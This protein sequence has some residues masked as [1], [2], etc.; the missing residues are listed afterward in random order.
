MSGRARADP[1]A[2]DRLVEQVLHPEADAPGAVAVGR[3]DAAAG[4][5]DLGAGEA[6]LVRPVEGHVVRHDHVRAAADPDLRTS[7]PRAASMSSSPISVAGLTTTPLPMTDV[8][9]G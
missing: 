5:A 1:L 4:R 6:G 8:M 3:P 7:M 2:E 9:C